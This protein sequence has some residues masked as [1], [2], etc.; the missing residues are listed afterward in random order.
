[1]ARPHAAAAAA[2]LGACVLA[3]CGGG[4]LD[5]KAL[6]QE[7]KGIESLAYEGDVLA[8]DAAQ[9]R[10]TSVFVRIHSGYLHAAAKASASKLARGGTP[11][12]RRLATLA[13]RVSDDIAQLARSGSD[14]TEQRRLQQDLAS[15]AKATS[16]LA[17]RL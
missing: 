5:R 8:D 6:Q 16:R 3:G 4:T 10:S 13:A 1:M 17:E 7:A 12:A 9:G 2:L 11:Q 14:R 15:A